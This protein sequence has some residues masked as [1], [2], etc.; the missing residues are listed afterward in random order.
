MPKSPNYR[1][2]VSPAA[3]HDI[4]KLKERILK[5]DFDRLANAVDKW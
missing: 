1:I 5:Q 2:E 4:Q 3:D